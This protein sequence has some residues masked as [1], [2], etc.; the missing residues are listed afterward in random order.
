MN[1]RFK[2]LVDLK[3]QSCLFS[4]IG[5]GDSRN[6]TRR[7]DMT[8]LTHGSPYSSVNS[9][10]PE[11][12]EPACV[13]LLFLHTSLLSNCRCPILQILC[14]IG[15]GNLICKITAA[16]CPH[17]LHILVWHFPEDPL[18]HALFYLRFGDQGPL[19]MPIQ[20]YPDPLGNGYHI[21]LIAV[22]KQIQ[23]LIIKPGGEIEKNEFVARTYIIEGV[24]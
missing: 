18:S 16:D 14:H 6:G 8:H 23:I 20:D 24:A 15:I 1:A 19:L 12:Q 21:D 11:T 4:V 22:T 7:N 13:F 10:V 9:A 3:T 5:Y 2:F 17:H